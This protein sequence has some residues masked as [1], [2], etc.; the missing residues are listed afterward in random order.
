MRTPVVAALTV[1]LLTSARLSFAQESSPPSAHGHMGDVNQAAV[2]GEIDFPTAATKPSHDAFVRGVLL[3]HNFHY[4]QAAEA[5]RKAQHLDSSD[6]MGYWGEAMTYTHPVWNEQD[7]AAADSVLRRLA[8]TPEARLAK[9]RTPRERQ[10]L[11]AVEALYAPAGTKARRDTAYAAVMARVH[12]TDPRDIEASTLYALALLGLNQGDRDVA[13]YQK[14]YEL[15]API[16]AAHPHHPGAAHYLIH[17]TDDPEHAA[18]GLAAAEAYSSIA[19]SATHAIHMTSHIFLA[20]GKWDDVVAANVRAQSTLPPDVLSP[21]IVHWLHYGLLQ[22]GRYR[23][24]DRWLDSMALQ[25]KGRP[26]PRR[27]VVY[28]SLGLMA[29]A[30]IV[31]SHRWNGSAGKVRVDGTQFDSSTYAAI[32]GDLAAS[33]FGVALGALFRGE[34]ALVDSTLAQMAS[35]RAMSASDINSA[36][37]RGM[38][39]VMEKTLRGYMLQKRGDQAGALNL[40]RDAAKEEASLPMPFGPPM[41]IKPPREAAGELLLEMKKPKE[42]RTEFLL[43]LGRTPRRTAPLLGLARAEWV[44]G[45]RAESR[46]NYR[47]MLSIW[48]AADSDLPELAEVRT[49]SR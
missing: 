38:S 24:A 35:Q 12:E 11:Q 37:S 20:L 3:L 39:E 47:E 23:E 15:V 19:P 9:A 27:A 14:A 41:T 22:Q 43:A 25:V 30:N 31:D 18:L 49:R 36:T 40:F 44:L 48:H 34:D 17:A 1:V 13:T 33:E 8:P 45:Q 26:N 42:A 16:F 7:T 46:K 2:L 29:G 32:L 10:W 6:V 5:F 4:P 21:H 28:S